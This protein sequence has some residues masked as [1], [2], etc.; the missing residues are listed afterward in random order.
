MFDFKGAIFDLDGT[1]LDSLDVW[2]VIDAEFL[3]A[4]GI[5]VPED[6][7]NAVKPLGFREAAVYTITR[8]GLDENPDDIV[9]EW[10]G[11]TK[12]AYEN[13][14]S[15]KPRAK[16]YLS[17]LKSKGVKLA[18]ATASEEAL[19]VPALKNNGVLGLFD[20]FATSSEVGKGKGHPDVYLKAA[21]KLN[22]LPEECAVFEDIYQGIAGAKAGHFFTIA[23]YDRHSENDIEKITAAADLLIRDYGEL[24]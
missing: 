1:L 16:E 2:S 15:L 12:K 23:V 5:K 13:D 9:R 7:E 17:F 11:M 24:L 21:E 3:G 6:Y 8:F 14:I 19:F 10:H 22:L 20:A 4:R 18:L